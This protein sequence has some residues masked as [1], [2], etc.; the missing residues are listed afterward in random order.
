MTVYCKEQDM[1]ILYDILRRH[2]L[3]LYSIGVDS[4]LDDRLRSIVS[5]A[6]VVTPQEYEQAVKSGKKDFPP[7]IVNWDKKILIDVS[8]I[9]GD[10]GLEDLETYLKMREL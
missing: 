5:N 2:K 9:R 8:H 3:C 1:D 10:I 4:V 7:K 6:A